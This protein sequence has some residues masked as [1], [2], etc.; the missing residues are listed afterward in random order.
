MR[1]HFQQSWQTLIESLVNF[2]A[3]AAG[4]STEQEQDHTQGAGGDAYETR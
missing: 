3:P 1:I 4:V 2:F